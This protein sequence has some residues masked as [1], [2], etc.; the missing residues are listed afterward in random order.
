MWFSET[1]VC[2]Q[3][4]AENELDISE[5]C[6]LNTVEIMSS[7]LWYPLCYVMVRHISF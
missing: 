2:V 6:D 3:L 7:L 5:I 1:L 4:I